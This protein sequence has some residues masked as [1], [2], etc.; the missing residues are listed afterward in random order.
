MPFRPT[1]ACP[2]GGVAVLSRDYDSRASALHFPTNG[3]IG[4]KDRKGSLGIRMLK[5]AV[6]MEI[7]ARNHDSNLWSMPIRVKAE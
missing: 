1:P 7:V 2:A 6:G 4:Q 5:A 3:T